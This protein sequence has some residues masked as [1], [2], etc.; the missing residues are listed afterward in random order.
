MATHQDFDGAYFTLQSL[1]VHHVDAIDECEL[2]VVDQSPDSRDGQ[3]FRVLCE[4]IGTQY[5]AMPE[6]GGTPA[7]HL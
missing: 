2:L 6:P 4:R 7:P 1:R 5:V 3:D